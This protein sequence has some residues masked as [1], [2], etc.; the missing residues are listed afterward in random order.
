VSDPPCACAIVGAMDSPRPVPRCRGREDRAGRTLETVPILRGNA[1]TGSRTANGNTARP[2]AARSAARPNLWR[3][4]RF[5]RQRFSAAVG[6]QRLLA[7][8]VTS[9]AAHAGKLLAHLASSAQVDGRAARRPRCANRDR[10]SRTM[11]PSR[12]VPGRCRLHGEIVRAF[13]L[14]PQPRQRRFRSCAW[15]QHAVRLSRY[16]AGDP[17]WC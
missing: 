7:A 9:P 10:A 12:R 14:Q 13:H 1:G 8:A 3:G 4:T 16:G 17:A 15:R 6:R 11:L 5:V 2:R